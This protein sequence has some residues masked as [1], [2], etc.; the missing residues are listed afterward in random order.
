MGRAFQA[1]SPKLSKGRLAT[2]GPFF[3]S[4]SGR[5]GV[6]DALQPSLFPRRLESRTIGAAFAAL[7]SRLRGNDVGYDR[8]TRDLIE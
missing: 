5:Y 2:G 8:M 1:S 6:P 3:W 4:G 7:D